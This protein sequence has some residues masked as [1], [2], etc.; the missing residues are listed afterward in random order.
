MAITSRLRLAGAWDPVR[1]PS[2]CLSTLI[3]PTQASALQLQHPSHFT[4]RLCLCLPLAAFTS[5]AG[6]QHP[7]LL[8]LSQHHLPAASQTAFPLMLRQTPIIFLLTNQFPA[9]LAIEAEVVFTLIR[10]VSGE[11]EVGE[12]R[13]G[14]RGCSR[15]RSS[16]GASSSS[17][18]DC[19]SYGAYRYM[20]HVQ[21]LC[22]DSEFMRSI[23]QR[24]NASA[25]NGD[26]GSA[27]GVRVFTLSVAT[28]HH[29]I[30]SRPSLLGISPQIQGMSIPTSMCSHSLDDVAETVVTAASATV[31]NF[32]GTITEPGPLRQTAQARACKLQR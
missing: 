26:T 10:P 15:W 18:H 6:S 4:H 19:C 29:L 24:Y 5:L 23:W 22:G 11:A 14:G 21:G 32:V 1:L 31:S 20:P 8:L 13:P 9:E 27:S 28:L 17:Y 25:T 7:K 12:A 2:P 16:E 3:S 30:I